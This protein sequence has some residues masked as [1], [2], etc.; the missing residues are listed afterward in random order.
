MAGVDDV[1]QLRDLV[2][3]ARR[4][5][6]TFSLT[7]TVRGRL[8]WA[9]RNWL[10][11]L[12]FGVGGCAAFLPWDR[13]GSS[14]DRNGVG[15]VLATGFIWLL[16]VTLT[17]VSALQLAV[18]TMEARR[19]RRILA[20]AVEANGR[21][22]GVLD[23]RSD[24]S[25]QAPSSRVLL[26]EFEDEHG[27]LRRGQ[28]VTPGYDIFDPGA[29]TKVLYSPRM[30]EQPEAGDAALPQVELRHPLLEGVGPRLLLWVGR[31]AMP[32]FMLAMGVFLIWLMLFV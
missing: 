17:L 27:R 15:D 19:R 18:S 5:V 8:A 28:A 32:V 7:R 6:A 1:A 3:R 23:D 9:G 11:L 13:I 12:A 26:V 10:M 22:V 21:V 30:L 24:P 20:E 2:V 29:R 14:L 25:G 16:G 31:W 4:H